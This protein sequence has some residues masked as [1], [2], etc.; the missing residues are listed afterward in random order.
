MFSEAIAFNQNLSVWDVSSVRNMNGMFAN[1]TLSLA[2]YDALLLG[3]SVQSLQPDAVFDGG[4]SQHSTFSQAARDTLINAFGW[5]V[6]DGG[7]ALAP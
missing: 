4:D 7:F 3:W 1:I 5:T 6:I 2:N